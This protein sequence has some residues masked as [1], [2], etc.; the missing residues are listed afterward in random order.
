MMVPATH[1]CKHSNLNTTAM[2]TSLSDSRIS[3]STLMDLSMEALKLYINYDSVDGRFT[4]HTP[5][6]T[7][8]EM[9]QKETNP[10][11]GC[12][13]K[14]AK[15]LSS[16]HTNKSDAERSCSY[17]VSGD[18]SGGES[19]D[20]EIDLYEMRESEG[21]ISDDKIVAAYAGQEVQDV[22]DEGIEGVSEEAPDIVGDK[23]DKEVQDVG[24]EG[25][26]GVSEEAPDVVGDKHDKEVQDVV[27]EG[28]KGV[29]EE[30]PDVV[31]DKHDKEVQDVS[32]EGIEG[33]SEE[34]PDVVGDKHDK[35]VQDIVD[36]GIK[37][38]REEAPDVVGDKHDKEV[39]DVSDEGIEGVSEE[40]P[41]VVGDKH[42][43][44]VQDVGD[45]GIEGV[46]E[47]APDIADPNEGEEVQDN[48]L[49][50]VADGQ[51]VQ[52][53][54]DI[55]T[56]TVE[57]EVFEEG[58]CDNGYREADF[59]T[60]GDSSVTPFMV[61]T[62]P[63]KMG[64]PKPSFLHGPGILQKPLCELEIRQRWLTVNVWKKEV[65]YKYET[66]EPRHV[67]SEPTPPHRK[68]PIVVED[69]NHVEK[70]DAV[71]TSS[72]RLQ[73]IYFAEDFFTQN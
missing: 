28:I 61:G 29:C 24:D 59:S 12:S 23:H 60:S 66:Y 27:D 30:A 40:A 17:T 42:D 16:E 58:V 38:V 35:E 14:R 56:G 43:K 36:E 1:T 15:R 9:P 2:S 3:V 32:D 49:V 55:G 45:E 63:R 31:G 65:F 21:D 4:P 18:V 10:A 20:S 64:T 5:P 51:E 71:V 11:Q 68:R 39:Q 13:N 54:S 37:G 6:E 52:E 62:P 41:D 19:A 73:T 25:I 50:N 72:K 53:I 8:P 44:E 34:A 22:G 48:V 67:S 7:P 26:E 46:R 70:K 57:H 47:E 69:D 33:V